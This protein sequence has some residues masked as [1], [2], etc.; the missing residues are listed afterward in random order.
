ML[1]AILMISIN[2]P[3]K[4]QTANAKPEGASFEVEKD[5]KNAFLRNIVRNIDEMKSK[6][7]T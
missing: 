4:N 6:W 2:N 7:A 3:E 5:G 1:K